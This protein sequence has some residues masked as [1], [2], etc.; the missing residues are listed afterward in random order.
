[1][2]KYKH[3]TTSDGPSYERSSS[4]R[5]DTLS[6]SER[7]LGGGCP[8]QHDWYLL[9]PSI[10]W[11]IGRNGTIQRFVEPSSEADSLSRLDL[12]GRHWRD[13]VS[14]DDHPI[15]EHAVRLSLATGDPFDIR[16]R[17]TLGTGSVQWYRTRAIARRD[18]QNRVVG[19]SGRSENI[20][21]QVLAK[22]ALRASEEHYRYTVEL[23]PGILWTAAANGSVDEVSSQWMAATGQ[24]VE[25]IWGI[26]WADAVHPDD[27]APTVAAWERAVQ[28]GEPVDIEYRI[29]AGGGYRWVRARAKARRNNAGEIVRWYGTLEDINDRKIAENALRENEQRFKLAV[30]AAEL[31]VWDFDNETGQQVWSHELKV[32]FGV[33]ADEA[34]EVETAC[35]LMHPDDRGILKSALAAPDDG[36]QQHEFD[37]VLRIRRANDGQERWLRAR[38]WKTFV[39]MGALMRALVTFR[40]ITD[41]R[42]ADERIRWM[43]TH[44]ALTRLPNRS[45]FQ[46]EV[47]CRIKQADGDPGC[48]P[49]ILIIDVD[50]LKETNDQL[51]HDA[52]DALLCALAERLHEV[53]PSG[54]F[55]ARLGGD[56]FGVALSSM[57][58]A[59]IR[60]LG[61]AISARLRQPLSY[62]QRILDCRASM[63][64]A[65]FPEHGLDAT[66]LIKAA[67]TALCAAKAA[68]RGHM[69]VFHPDLR[70]EARRRAEMIVCAR[71]AIDGDRIRPFYQPK[72]DLQSGQVS[73]FEALL[74]WHTG[75]GQMLP[76][77]GIS[78]AFENMELATELHEL[79]FRHIIEDMRRWLAAGLDFG[80]V[81]INTAPAQFM[82]GNFA[83]E[84]LSKLVTEHV[85]AD[86]FEVEVTENIFL[87][88]R[89]EGVGRA[90]RMLSSEGVRIALDD[91]GTGYASLT[92]LQAF[93]VNVIKIDRSF[94]TDLD[95][96]PGNVAI[97][98]AVIALSHKLGME[99]VAE[100]VEQASQC[101]FL[102][103][104]GC[105][106]V[107]GFL[108]SPAISAQQVP[109][110]LLQSWVI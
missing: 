76:P 61:S 9:D 110:L 69:T 82:R 18:A 68:D 29:G 22:E 28:T 33:S 38:G 92:H 53:L 30:R 70:R 88:R 74:R 48:G 34:P 32:I 10:R 41:E 94:M 47:E 13:L 108:F 84:F 77:A 17:L 6:T 75:D 106:T 27:F 63:G 39:P 26:G 104:C 79:M 60:R 8:I 19:W 83:E 55:V 87:G 44:D 66:D 20:H 71:R 102:R 73:G 105:N 91:F 36:N 16:C 5:P 97:V 96:R 57:S 98:Q 40:D 65:S 25:A 81:A 51:G 35:R 37:A 85:P 72:I 23:N 52:G 4:D 80:R 90:L 56:E 12:V 101:S 67:D 107:Q 78:A 54:A 43:A 42:N 3:T 58:H 95:T 14:G 50:D 59:D 64:A 103:Q 100:G 15:I 46:H 21:D 2:P 86:R 11:L 24:T 7:E 93:P 1:M 62:A 109:P 45:A 49:V 31:G 99:T 89:A